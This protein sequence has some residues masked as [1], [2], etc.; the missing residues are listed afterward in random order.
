MWVD[1]FCKCPEWQYSVKNALYS[2]KILLNSTYL[3]QFLLSFSLQQLFSVSLSVLVHIMDWMVPVPS[4]LSYVTIYILKGEMLYTE[5]AFLSHFWCKFHLWNPLLLNWVLFW[6]FFSSLSLLPLWR[7]ASAV[8]N[9]LGIIPENT[10]IFCFF[11][12]TL[13]WNLNFSVFF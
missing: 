11:S 9:C 1:L 6:V 12:Q 4:H 8:K 10:S 5:I 3:N 13:N 2:S 7:S